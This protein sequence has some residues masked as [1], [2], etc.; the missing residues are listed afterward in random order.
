MFCF[1][2]ASAHLHICVGIPMCRYLKK[3]PIKFFDQIKWDKYKHE[4]GCSVLGFFLLYFIGC[5]KHNINTANEEQEVPRLWKYPTNV[6]ILQMS[7]GTSS[8]QNRMH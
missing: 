2:Y 4:K 1:A 5:N 7:I 6:H 3:H 8:A